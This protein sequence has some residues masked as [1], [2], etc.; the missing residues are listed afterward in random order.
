MSQCPQRS[1]GITTLISAIQELSLIRTYGRPPVF[2]SR[3][4]FGPFL[5]LTCG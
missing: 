4:P 2:A 1:A 3:D 5:F